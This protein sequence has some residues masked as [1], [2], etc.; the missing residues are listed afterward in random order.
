MELKLNAAQEIVQNK[1]EA[2]RK[3]GKPVR[4]VILK[5]RQEGIS[6]WTSGV[7]FHDTAT[8][9]NRITNS[10]AHD[11]EATKNLLKMAKT[12]YDNL[13]EGLAPMKRY[14]NVRSLVF[15]NPDEE[16]K[17]ARPG[18]GSEMAIATAKKK[19]ARG[20]TIHNLHCSEV[21]FGWMLQR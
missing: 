7:F 21:A 3:E 9:R 17:K 19:E 18:L 6:T 8:R 14:D 2:K 11:P 12:F 5:A 4:F 1:L 13:P 16:D 10:I 15:E 20:G